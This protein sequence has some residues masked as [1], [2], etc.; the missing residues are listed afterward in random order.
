MGTAKEY[1]EKISFFLLQF[2]YKII[3]I[4]YHN[5]LRKLSFNLR[6]NEYFE[7]LHCL[8]SLKNI[9][10][11]LKTSE[12]FVWF[13]DIIEGASPIQLLY[14]SE[15]LAE[16]FK[17]SKLNLTLPVIQMISNALHSN[18]LTVIS[19]NAKNC[20]FED[21]QLLGVSS[22]GLHLFLKSKFAS[23]IDLGFVKGL[24]YQ[25]TT[26]LSSGEYMSRDS[27]LLLIP[28]IIFINIQYLG[29]NSRS[30]Y[31]RG[32]T[33]FYQGKNASY[34][35]SNWENCVSKSFKFLDS[36]E[37]LIMRSV[38]N[39]MLELSYNKAMWYH[40]I[41]FDTIRAWLKKYPK[42]F[43]TRADI[44]QRIF[45]TSELYCD[46]RGFNAASTCEEIQQICLKLDPQLLHRV[47]VLCQSPWYSK[48]TLYYKNI[49][50]GHSDVLENSSV[51]SMLEG[52][53]CHLGYNRLDHA[54]LKA[55]KTLLDKHMTKANFLDLL[56]VC[57]LCLKN[58]HS[59]TWLMSLYVAPLFKK[60]TIFPSG[61]RDELF[62]ILSF[63]YT[64]ENERIFLFEIFYNF[65]K[66]HLK[67]MLKTS[68]VTKLQHFNI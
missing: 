19:K 51:Q 35:I 38:E 13:C 41:H 32:F 49:L 63:W 10:E 43:A 34:L 18:C 58:N 56:K 65:F 29:S 46:A 20:S 6:M 66:G 31:A 37:D 53:I 54:T 7:T 5:C 30:E 24:C 8:K 22:L 4:H 45:S 9:N 64:T 1:F 15:P 33:L 21:I 28:L 3:N 11:K 67:D 60:D 23:K 59:N 39:S 62:Q 25:L 44:L 17:S 16:C 61:V 68:Q 12:D 52:L 14:L 57:L 48:N 47:E 40:Y 2:K 27:L 55:I 26:F 50:L 36:D 42:L